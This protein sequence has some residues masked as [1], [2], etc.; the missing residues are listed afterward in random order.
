MIYIT[1]L[2]A[3]NSGHLIGKWYT[4]PMAQEELT[5][6][7]QE[8]LRNGEK[9][10]HDGQAHEEVFI[11][12]YESEI[13]IGE[14]DG[15]YRLNELAE[16]MADYDEHDLLKLRFLSYDGYNE[17]DIIDEGL[18]SYEVDIYDYSEDTSFTDVYELLAYDFVDDGL[19]G[20]IPSHLLHYIDYSAIGRDLSMDYTEFEHGVLGRMA[21]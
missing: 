8:V 20:E 7:I 9:V 10:C 21:S 5:E 11:T 2:S 12:D 19:F 18:D 3:Y 13:I 4:L 15:I 1:D 6:A 14:Y 16:S 17:R